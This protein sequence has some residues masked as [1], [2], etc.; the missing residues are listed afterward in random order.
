[1]GVTVNG[2]VGRLVIMGIMVVFPATTSVAQRAEGAGTL[3]RPW[4]AAGE[5]GVGNHWTLA[6][7]LGFY[8]ALGPHTVIAGRA[9]AATRLHPI[10]FD[11]CALPPCPDPP[12]P[13]WD[14]LSYR[15]TAIVYGWHV[16][17]ARTGVLVA[18]GLGAISSRGGRAGDPVERT[19]F[20]TVGLA[21]EARVHRC[22]GRIAIHLAVKGNWNDAES[23]AT[24]TVGASAG[25]R[26]CLAA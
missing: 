5:L 24:A 23:F 8:Y 9:L 25:R 1:V 15:E 19:R 20:S 4:W 22:T 12:P 26:L 11:L 10:R 17:G 18:A 3:R 16:T 2:R 14:R 7:G 6:V 21:G 13:A